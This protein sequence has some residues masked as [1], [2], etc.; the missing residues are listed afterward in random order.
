MKNPRWER[1]LDLKRLTL[2]DALMTEVS[3]IMAEELLRDWP[4]QVEGL[5]VDIG[6]E[7][8]AIFAVGSKRP[9][10]AAFTIALR[11]ARWDLERNFDAYDD[12]MRNRRYEAEGLVEADRIAILFL[13]RWLVEQML[14]LGDA[15]DTRVKRKDMVVTLDRLE[16]RL[17]PS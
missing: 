2:V 17:T 6:R 16:K 5:D 8:S 11:L 13:C 10:Q 12:F 7:F 3:K 9:P 14:S 1:L 4:P 15:T